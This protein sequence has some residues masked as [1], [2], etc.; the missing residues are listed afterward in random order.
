MLMGLPE[1]PPGGADGIE[2]ETLR[3]TV[4]V[5]VSVPD[6]PVMVSV[7]LPT[8][9]LPVVV[10]VSVELAGRL[11]ELGLND[12]TA[13]AGKPVTAKFTVPANPFTD[14]PPIV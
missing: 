2:A 9:V 10:T 8:G 14:P 1:L 6:V 4:V 11:I 3:G 12:A 13:P 7:T 5:C